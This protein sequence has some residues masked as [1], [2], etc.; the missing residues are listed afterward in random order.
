MQLRRVSISIYV[1]FIALWRGEITVA[2]AQTAVV[3][4]FHVLTVF[5]TRWRTAQSVRDIVGTLAEKSGK[6]PSRMVRLS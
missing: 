1:V 2:D 5:Q 3:N 6:L 4:T